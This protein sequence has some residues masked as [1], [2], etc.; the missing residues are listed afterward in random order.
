MSAVLY[1]GKIKFS[2]R[3]HENKFFTAGKTARRVAMKKKLLLIMGLLVLA[4]AVFAQDSEIMWTS[5]G[6]RA[7]VGYAYLGKYEGQARANNIA[8]DYNYN[9]VQPTNE[10]LE[11][12]RWAL[13]KYN[14]TVGDTFLVFFSL[15][16]GVYYT[17]YCEF[18]TSERYKYW[19]YAKTNW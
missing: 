9:Y 12:I 1:R 15:S 4:T 5:S 18:T 8:N 2:W 6:R 19:V 16:R 10:H 3:I 13:N 11:I 17:A 14:Y 7:N